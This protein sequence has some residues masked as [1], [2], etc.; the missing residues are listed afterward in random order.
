MKENSYV[1]KRRNTIYFL[2]LQ[3]VLL[4]I[5]GTK[6]YGRTYRKETVSERKV[7]Q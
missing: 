1:S 4:K 6:S 2:D 7:H 5:K 3:E